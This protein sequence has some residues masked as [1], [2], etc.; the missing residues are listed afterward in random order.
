M[1]ANAIQ[2]AIEFGINVNVS[3]GQLKPRAKMAFSGRWDARHKYEIR[4]H[5]LRPL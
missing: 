4:R 5:C 3:V 1:K 2:F